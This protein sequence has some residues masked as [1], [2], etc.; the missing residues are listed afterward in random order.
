MKRANRIGLIHEPCNKAYKPICEHI[1]PVFSFTFHV[2]SFRIYVIGSAL[3]VQISKDSALD[4]PDCPN[5]FS[6]ES[7]ADLSKMNCKHP[8]ENHHGFHDP[9]HLPPWTS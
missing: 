4:D 2:G 8:L 1:L 3:G 9:N 5:V 7:I 6:E